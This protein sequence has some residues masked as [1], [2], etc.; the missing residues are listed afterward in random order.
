MSKM[1]PNLL[2]GV[3]G[4]IH[5]LHL[6]EY[7]VAFRETFAEHIKVILT[8]SAARMVTTDVLELFS[9]DR[10][11]TDLWDRSS[12]TKSPHIQLTRTADL[13]VVI[14]ATANIIGKAA[15]GIADDLLSTAILAYPK[16]IV[17]G[18]AMNPTMWANKA[19]QRNLETLYQ[20]GHYI[21]PPTNGV[22]VTTGTWD[23]GLAPTP[24]DALLHA[25]HI[26]MKELRAEYWEEATRD[27]PRTPYV[28]KLLQL[29]VAR[30]TADVHP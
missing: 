1:C 15:N 6:H 29:Q 7:L 11:Y 3:S 26:R 24:Q 2:F 19:L 30:E 13:F 9:D 4:S 18:P 22:S 8:P 21:I 5:V 25:Q 10:V 12:D 27:K 20:D 23:R 14:P 16:T 28:Q 17:F